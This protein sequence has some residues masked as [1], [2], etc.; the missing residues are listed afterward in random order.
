VSKAV[1][2]DGPPETLAPGHGLSLH[3]R[4]WLGPGYLTLS[5][6]FLALAGLP[7]ARLLV[8][9]A[10]G[11]LTAGHGFWLVQRARGGT[12]PNVV[13]VIV[14]DLVVVAVATAVSGG[15]G[16][17]HL[18]GLLAPTAAVAAAGRPE[19]M[20]WFLLVTLGVL[21]AFALLPAAVI[22]VA[23][24]AP[25][26]L[27]VVQVLNGVIT[28]LYLS[29][30]VVTLSTRTA[31]T[32]KNLTQV[33][34]EALGEA[35]RRSRD[36]EAVGMKVAHELKNPLAA[37]KSLLQLELGSRPRGEAHTR[38]ELMGRQ[39]AH[40]EAVLRDYLSFSRP[41]EGLNLA[42]RDLRALCDDVVAALEPSVRAAR[43][44]LTCL[45]DPVVVRGDAHRLKEALLNLVTNALEATS[46]DGQIT[47]EV[48]RS[49]R[50]ARLRVRDT[51]RGMSPAVLAR[52]GTPFFTT[53]PDGTGLGVVVARTV[54][55]Q[56]GGSL[57]FDSRSGGGTTVTIDIPVDAA[58]APAPEPTK[59][60]KGEDSGQST[61][62]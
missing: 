23:Y 55:E 11:L 45:G 39:V 6:V 57:H 29:R 14:F 49:D 10:L 5:V 33:R 61:A 44:S 47:L 13:G 62:G 56:H 50:G 19:L 17:P 27:R 28:T 59:T 8:T 15:L 53:R 32:R 46:P 31:A 9:A 41:V 22:G 12:P 37:I 43:V 3:E 34:H 21:L 7:P 54:I 42:P 25:G 58:P 30:V 60:T 2:A 48:S 35:G 18:L 16:S 1:P 51:G 26:W 20:R 4:R 52:V 40:M 36:L 38:V 24:S